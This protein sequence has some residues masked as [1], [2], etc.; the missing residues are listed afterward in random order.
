M[1][2]IALRL[3]DRSDDA[4]LRRFIR[5]TEM[6]GRIQTAFLREPSYFDALEVEGAYGE[7]AMAED[8]G[9]G[10]IVSMAA[11]SVKP[12]Y[13]NGE[14]APL[15][16]LSN[17]RVAEDYRKGT[18]LARVY[19]MAKAQHQDGRARLYLTTIIDDNTEAKQVLTSRR[20]GLPAYRDRGKFFTL[21]VGLG[22]TNPFSSSDSF[23]VRRATEKDADGVASFLNSEGPKKQFFPV[24]TADD[25]LSPVGLL[26]GLSMEDVFLAFSGSDLVGT[27]A[28][29]DQRAFRQAMIAGYGGLVR[30]GRPA[31]NAFARV[32]G[33]PRLPAPG[34]TLDFCHLALV[35]VKD[36]ACPIFET[37]MVEVFDALRSRAF[38]FF[39]VGLHGSDP[40]LSCMKR[41]KC[42][43][44]TTRLY[45]AHWEDGE[46]EYERLDERTP[47]LEVGAL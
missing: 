3:A 8:R 28:T 5:S 33:Y 34:S 2:R 25:L 31:Y 43:R 37:L 46:E 21:A 19:R 7:V 15:G 26:R 4:G 42:F 30:M 45:V 1:K 41:A 29:W 12:A 13:L 35:C 10:R 38:S 11:R 17:L 40:L 32:T 47:Y 6:D 22:Q 16:Y 23:T 27:V 18:V 9:S 44:Y 20:C 14:R 39:T 24:Y 36:N